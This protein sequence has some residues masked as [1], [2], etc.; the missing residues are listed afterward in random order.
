MKLDL[1]LKIWRSVDRVKSFHLTQPSAPFPD[2]ST[3]C[4]LDPARQMPLLP[5]LH[6]ARHTPSPHVL[7]H[8]KPPWL[9]H[10]APQH[11]IKAHRLHVVELILTGLGDIPFPRV[12]HPFFSK[13][14]N[15][16]AFFCVIFKRTQHSLRSFTFFIKERS[17]LCVLLR[18]L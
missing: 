10:E 18:S 16:L 2:Y 8:L 1:F 6:Q 13:E 3:H 15:V 11:L 4:P 5:S 14:C 7:T 12:G 9:L 17:V